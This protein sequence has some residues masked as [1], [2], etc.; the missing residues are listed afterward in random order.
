MKQEKSTKSGAFLFAPK[1]VTCKIDKVRRIFSL[2]SKTEFLKKDSDSWIFLYFN[3]QFLKTSKNAK[4][5][6][7]WQKVFIY[8][9]I[10]VMF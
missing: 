1:K 5:Y 7:A 6:C 4:V 8:K 9:K 3:N 2:K 10:W